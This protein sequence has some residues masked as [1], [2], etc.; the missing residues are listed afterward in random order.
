MVLYKLFFTVILFLLIS[1]CSATVNNRT[2]YSL[3]NYRSDMLHQYLPYDMGD[4]VLLSVMSIKKDVNIYVIKNS[5]LM[6]KDFYILLLYVF[7]IM[8]K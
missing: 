8:L 5:N 7:V 1:S 3:A 2:S 4:M 6:T